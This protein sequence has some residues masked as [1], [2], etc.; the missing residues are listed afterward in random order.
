MHVKY[1]ITIRENDP[2]LQFCF[3]SIFP[4]AFQGTESPG[5]SNSQAIK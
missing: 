1:C 5:E 2:P 4:Y 3:F